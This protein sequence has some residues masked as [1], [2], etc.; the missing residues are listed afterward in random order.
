MLSHAV[1]ALEEVQVKRKT[2]WN[3]GFWSSLLS[4]ES[5][6]SRMSGRKWFPHQT[7]RLAVGKPTVSKMQR[8]FK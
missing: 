6:R 5:H 7:I 1:S 3:A 4:W 8:G 2:F